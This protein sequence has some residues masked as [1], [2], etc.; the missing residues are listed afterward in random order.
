L[1]DIADSVSSDA[2]ALGQSKLRPVQP[3]EDAARKFA[4]LPPKAW[5]KKPFQFRNSKEYS[6][7]SDA[8]VIEVQG[9]SAG[10][11]VRQR[12]AGE[13]YKFLAALHA[14]NSLEGQE[15]EGPFEAE[16]AARKL[17]RQSPAA[18]RRQASALQ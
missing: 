7:M 11:I 8:Y 4:K 15:F 12:Q 18:I 1:A 3:E 6:I 16:C 5:R 13:H 17:Y 10:I 9:I 14:F 2:I